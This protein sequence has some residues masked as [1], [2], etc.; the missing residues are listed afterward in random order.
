MKLK[1]GG[2]PLLQFA[3]AIPCEL[4]QNQHGESSSGCCRNTVFRGVVKVS[5]DPKTSRK[6]K[7]MEGGLC[8]SGSHKEAKR[9]QNA[10]GAICAFCAS[11]QRKNTGLQSRQARQRIT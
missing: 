2:R 5:L 7:N 4:C 6:F 9:A 8:R 10:A 1:R 3:T 11:L